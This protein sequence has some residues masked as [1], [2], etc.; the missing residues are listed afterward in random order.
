V[1]LRKFAQVCLVAVALAPVAGLA[2]PVMSASAAQWKAKA[3]D[4]RGDIFY[5]WGSTRARAA[6]NAI[7]ACVRDSTYA[8]TCDIDWV[9]QV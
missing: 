9:R 6:A 4:G 1:K 8:R 3:D 7:Y 2:A 5:A